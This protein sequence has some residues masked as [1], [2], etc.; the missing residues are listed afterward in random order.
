[1]R[2]FSNPI[3]HRLKWSVALYTVQYDVKTNVYSRADI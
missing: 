2:Y 1:M 3:F